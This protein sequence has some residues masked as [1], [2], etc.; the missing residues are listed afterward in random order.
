MK[1]KVFLFVACLVLLLVF[2]AKVVVPFAYDIAASDIFLEDSGDEA[3]RIST[4]NNMTNEAF[5][6][7]N[8]HIANEILA[9]DYT[10]I[11]AK[12]PANAFSLGSYRYVINA[13]IEIQPTDGASF[14]RLYVCRIKYSM[15]DDSDPSIADNWSVEG[16]SG[17]NDV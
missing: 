6:Q 4:N 1:N 16:L 12:T 3:S 7:C 14:R 15:T 2:Q 10:L 13:D 17:L 5:E 11:F 9:D 8:N